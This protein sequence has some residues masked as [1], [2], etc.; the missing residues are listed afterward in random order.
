MGGRAHLAWMGDPHRYVIRH[1]TH[2]CRGSGTA[3]GDSLEHKIIQVN[4]LLEAFGNAQTNLNDNSSRFG[5][6][7]E[8]IFAESGA[9]VGAKISEYVCTLFLILRTQFFC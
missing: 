4:P 5:K 2:L 9:V 6:Y 3:A 1:I 8:L 7:T